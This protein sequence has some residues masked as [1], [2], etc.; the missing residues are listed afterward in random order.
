MRWVRYRGSRLE[1]EHE[2]GNRVRIRVRFD[3]EEE[4]LQFALSF[5]A[6]VDVIAPA[7]LRNKV[8]EGARATIERY[9][10]DCNPE[11]NDT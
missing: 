8:L 1:E 6:D 9:A 4:A 11:P 5:G 7:E 2:E 3:A 10:S